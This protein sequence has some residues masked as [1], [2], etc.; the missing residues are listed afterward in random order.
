MEQLW[1]KTG[2]PLAIIFVISL[3]LSI[4]SV[5]NVT[6]YSYHETGSVQLN[7]QHKLVMVSSVWEQIVSPHGA[8]TV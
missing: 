4:L 3:F 6:K 7:A 8:A 5:P 1:P 2:N